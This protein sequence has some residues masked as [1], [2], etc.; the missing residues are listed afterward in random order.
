MRNLRTGFLFAFIV[1]LVGSVAWAFATPLT[2]TPD[3]PS[4]IVR[5]VAVAHGEIAPVGLDS[6]GRQLFHVPAGYANIQQWPHCFAHKPS[7]DAACQAPVRG[8][9]GTATTYSTAGLYNP[10]YYAIVGWPSLIFHDPAVAIYA[11]RI[12][13]AV[14]S[15]AMAAGAFIFLTV[16]MGRRRAALVIAGTVTPM[17]LFLSASVNPNA[18]EITGGMLLLTSLCALL[19]REQSSRSRTVA[20]TTVA[21]SAAIVANM[22]GVSPLWVAVIG[23]LVL[24]LT[25][26]A[27]LAA[28]ARRKGAWIAVG[29]VVLTALISVAWTAAAGAFTLKGDFRGGNTWTAGKVLLYMLQRTLF[30]TGYVGVFGWTD[31]G[32]PLVAVVL[33]GCIVPVIAVLAFAFGRRRA[34][35]VLALA[36]VAWL[37]LPALIQLMYFRSAGIIWQARYT[38]ILYVTIG[39]L[40]A[41]IASSRHPVG[42]RWGRLAAVVGGIVTFAH[43][44]TFLIVLARYTRGTKAT[45]WEALSAPAWQPP[46]GILL[47]FLVTVACGVAF[48]A[49][50]VRRDDHH[51]IAMTMEDRL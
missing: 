29:V 50:V 39:I 18:W 46:G 47:W 19:L 16:L 14:V 15:S 37:V 7:H 20:L 8:K 9:S 44:Y 26:G 3:E 51:D 49:F 1:L 48:T 40:G 17:V 35:L 31:V 11:M 41:V 5:A 30:E 24:L 21:V 38:M 2:A 36:V 45:I 22:R 27:R 42:Q 4:H 43:A 13:T 25:P 34:V 23:V 33:L 32:A 12:L 6:E 10:L 28:L